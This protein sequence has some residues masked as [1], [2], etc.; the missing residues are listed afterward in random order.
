MKHFFLKILFLVIVAFAVLLLVTRPT[1]GA[2]PAS[3]PVVVE[4]FTSEGCSSCPPADA[5]LSQLRK[6]GAENGFEIIPLGFHV[7]YWNYQGWQDRFS[8]RDYSKR[9]E[10]YA[11]QFH[12][13]GPYTPQMIVDGSQ[14]FV[15]NDAGRARKAIM[16]AG[17][18]AA[19]ARVSLT[20]QAGKIMVSVAGQPSASGE[21]WLAITEDDLTSHV[22][23]GENTGRTLHHDAVVRECKNIGQL[24]SGNFEKAVPLKLQHDWKRSDLRIVAFVQ[25]RHT[26]KI[27]GAAEVPAAVLS[28]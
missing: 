9:Q 10:V 26:G 13:E 18:Q 15:G 7:D 17:A 21:V 22:A 5:L 16:E 6:N 8:S 20:P 3:R 19:A 11:E 4:L 2:N 12:I 23:A 28:N 27:T 25:D 24:H 14:E 1:Q